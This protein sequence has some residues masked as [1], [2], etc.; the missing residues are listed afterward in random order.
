MP[1]QQT[2]S[3]ILAEAR[4]IID[5][6]MNCH[7]AEYRVLDKLERALDQLCG[8]V[9]ELNSAVFPLRDR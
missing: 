6:Q 5:G 8:E 1:I 3:E 7:T 4:E 2:V 9:A